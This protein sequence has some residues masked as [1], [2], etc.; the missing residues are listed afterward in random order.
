MTRLIIARHGNTFGPGDTVTY[1][2]GRT[3]LPLV[4]SGE[5]QARAIGRYLKSEGLL[6]DLVYASPLR[7]T[8]ETAALALSEMGLGRAVETLAMLRE[9]DYGPDENQTKDTV[10]AR[11][12]LQALKDWDERGIMPPGWQAE[13]EAIETDWQDFA[14]KTPAGKTVLIVTSNGIARFAPA[15]TSNYEEFLAS[16]N[17][18]LGTGALGLLHSDEK[19]WKVVA[20]NIRPGH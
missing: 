7:R 10:I 20:W 13:P 4:V 14:A 12:G 15:I 1:V 5:A 19:S 17:P 3:D 8:Q 18:K 11:I 2:G 9:I 6:P 16:Y